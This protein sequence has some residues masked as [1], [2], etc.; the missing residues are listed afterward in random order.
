MIK[1]SLANIF[2]WFLRVSGTNLEF[3]YLSEFETEFKKKLGYKSRFHM[4]S[5]LKKIRDQ[6]SCAIVPLWQVFV[7]QR[8]K[9]F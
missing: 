5:I 1:S 3:E 9:P 8:N 6:K 7:F 2:F 4:G